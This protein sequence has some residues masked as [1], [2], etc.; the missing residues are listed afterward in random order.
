MYSI[1]LLSDDWMCQS[2]LQLTD[3]KQKIVGFDAQA[4]QIK[5][6][7]EYI[8]EKAN[9]ESVVM[10]STQRFNLQ[11]ETSIKLSAWYPARI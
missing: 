3:M 8:T 7:L 11:I 2:F 5:V 9:R 6:G 10:D 4:N 1:A